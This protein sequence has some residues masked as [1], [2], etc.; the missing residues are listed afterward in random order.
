MSAL[1]ACDSVD[2]HELG[3][4][5]PTYVTCLE[6]GQYADPDAVLAAATGR[7]LTMFTPA[8]ESEGEG[9]TMSVP[10]R[11]MPLLVARGG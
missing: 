2:A 5:P 7:D 8:V 6:V 3:M 10:E 11:S 9:A 4:M 1:R